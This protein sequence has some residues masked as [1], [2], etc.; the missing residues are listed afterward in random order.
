MYRIPSKLVLVACLWLSLSGTTALTARAASGDIGAIVD[1]SD[2]Y[3]TEVITRECPKPAVPY[4]ITPECAEALSAQ[5]MFRHTLP[6]VVHPDAMQAESAASF[7]ESAPQAGVR[8]PYLQ[9]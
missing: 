4:G 9:P 1:P 5:A 6:I 7:A 8:W 3:L 2:L